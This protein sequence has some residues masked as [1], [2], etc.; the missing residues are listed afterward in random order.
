MPIFEFIDTE[1]GETFEKIISNNE[2]E[3]FLEENPHIKQ[4]LDAPL[5]SME[6]KRFMSVRRVDQGW[7]DVLRK[8]HSKTP[9][10]QLTN[11]STIGF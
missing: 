8:V 3:L 11:T 4:L 7:K 9:G 10:S 1:S 6:S 5:I 2:K